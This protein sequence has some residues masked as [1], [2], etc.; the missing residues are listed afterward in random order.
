MLGLGAALLAA[1]ASS[2]PPRPAEHP[3]RPK[4][5]PTPA[6]QA[7]VP[8]PPVAPGG[9]SRPPSAAEERLIAELV[10]ETERIRQLRFKAPVEVRIQDR[11]AMRAYVSRTIAQEDLVRGR[12][13]YVALGL[14]DPSVDVRELLESLMEEELIGYYDPKQK[15]LAVRDDVARSLGARNIDGDL[16]WR[17][18]VVH[19]LVHALQD[20]HLGLGAAME[21][22]RTTDAD[23]AFGAL[24]EGDATLAMIGYAAG[25]SGVSLAQIASDPVQLD[26]SLGASPDHLTGALR[27][28]PAIV[29]EPLLFRY[30]AGAVFSAHLYQRGG[31]A[32]VDRAH[33]GPPTDTLSI[34][35]PH[36]YRRAAAEYGL[37]LPELGWLGQRGFRAVDEDVL[38]GIELGIALGLPAHEAARI[39][40]SWRGDRYAVLEHA[41]GDASVW[42][43]RLVSDASGHELERR[44]AAMPDPTRTPRTISRW[45]RFVLVVR[46]LPAAET[47]ELLARFRAWVRAQPQP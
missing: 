45:G 33:A 43:L 42:C 31:W 38:G 6:A 23:D 26:A 17:A 18:T 47:G 41:S 36:R 34:V 40:R 46:G 30:R 20:Q 7:P 16:E 29:R 1:C 37:S 35:A 22:E 21:R 11:A 12:R 15:L 25:K 32:A 10:A 2:A 3:A 28:A 8:A 5:E 44:L 19:E 14:L 24:V 13:R 39:A 9:L 27:A 4:P